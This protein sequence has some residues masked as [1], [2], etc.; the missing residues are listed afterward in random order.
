MMDVSLASIGVRSN[1]KGFA[2]VLGVA[3]ILLGVGA[4]ASYLLTRGDA[5]AAPAGS[6]EATD[7]FVIGTPLPEGANTPDVDIVSG[8]ESGSGASGA[9]TMDTRSPGQGGRRPA[10]PTGSTRPHDHD[11]S[12][13]MTAAVMSTTTTMTAS[14]MTASTMSTTASTMTGTMDTAS[15]GGTGGGTDTAGAG[16]GGTNASD[17]SAGG[18]SGGGTAETGGSGGALPT[19]APEESDIELDMYGARVRFVV[20]RYYAARARSCFDRATRNNPGVSGTVIVNMTINASGQVGS[21]SVA[22]NTTGDA[23]LG[24]CLAGQ[25]GQWRLPPPPGGELQ[26][27][28][29]FSR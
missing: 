28:M 11:T 19:D 5:N 16:S 2:V 17:M 18:G 20:R 7:P 15:S 10:Q 25:V 8:G 21:T 3:A 6:A 27:Q 12:T 4:G 13:A 23:T 22:R 1:K 24:A 29:P 14:T 9:A 26:M